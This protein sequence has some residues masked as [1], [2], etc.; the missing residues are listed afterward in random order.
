[1]FLLRWEIRNGTASF[2]LGEILLER[3]KNKQIVRLSI[4]IKEDFLSTTAFLYGLGDSCGDFSIMDTPTSTTLT[5]ILSTAK[6][7]A[8]ALFTNWVDCVYQNRKPITKR[9]S[10]Q[11]TDKSCSSHAHSNS[12]NYSS[13]VYSASGS[14]G[15]EVG[16][17]YDS[18]PNFGRGLTSPVFLWCVL[19]IFFWPITL[20][21][22]FSIHLPLMTLKHIQSLPI[23]KVSLEISL[24]KSD[25]IRWVCV[26]AFIYKFPPLF[27]SLSLYICILLCSIMLW[28]FL[29][30]L[31]SSICD[32]FFL[33][34]IKN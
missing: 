29:F 6:L 7:L 26:C 4:F 19:C 17:K 15:T 32:S 20:L 23:Y 25:L 10:S 1:M 8:P 14:E 31:V 9:S 28:L 21:Y 13:S 34:I 11:S 2:V 12:V 3:Y 18:I 30:F 33:I 24:K 16:D 27:S 22:V 5:M